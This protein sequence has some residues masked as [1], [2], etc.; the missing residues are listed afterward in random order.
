MGRK[1]GSKK[2]VLQV[3]IDGEWKYVFCR[4]PQR[5]NPITTKKRSKAL[6][7]KAKGYFETKYGNHKF[8]NTTK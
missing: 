3:Q 2:K 5:R 7:G 6:P 1:P 4:N 8:R